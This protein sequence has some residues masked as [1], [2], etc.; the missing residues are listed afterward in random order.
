MENSLKEPAIL[1][2]A[3]FTPQQ[4]GAQNDKM[5]NSLKEPAI[6]FFAEFT[7]QQCGAQNDKMFDELGDHGGGLQICG[8][9][10]TSEKAICRIAGAKKPRKRPFADLRKPENFGKGDLQDCG[11]LFDL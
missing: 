8:S 4:C 10:I 3:E 9:Q 5:E 1:F 6:L 7:P 11:M 2:F